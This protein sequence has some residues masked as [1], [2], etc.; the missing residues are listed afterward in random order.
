MQVDALVV[1][2]QSQSQI[3]I[4]KDEA[5]VQPSRS[6]LLVQLTFL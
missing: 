1:Q 4:G 3:D 6:K 2:S 5:E